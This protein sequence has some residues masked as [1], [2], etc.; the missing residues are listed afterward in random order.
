MSGEVRYQDYFEN[1]DATPERLRQAERRGLGADLREMYLPSGMASGIKRRQIERPLETAL[2]HKW[3]D[4]Q[5]KQAG[6][7]FARHMVFAGAQLGFTCSGWREVVDASPIRD[8]RERKRFHQ[9]QLRTAL[10]VLHPPLRQPFLDWMVE[11]E[12]QDTSVVELGAR[13]TKYSFRDAQ[14]AVGIC[15][16]DLILT[17]LAHHFGFL[18]RPSSWDTRRALEELLARN[19]S[20]WRIDRD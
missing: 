10:L 9:Q 16:L 8:G 7:E 3:I 17:D 19:E 6:D 12:Q 5:Q 20:K 14:K 4:L 15:V 1:I 18:D 13:L 2:R 11:A